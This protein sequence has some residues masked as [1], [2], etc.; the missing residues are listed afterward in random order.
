[1]I[2]WNKYQSKVTDQAQNRYLDYL[3]DPRF[4]RVNRLFLL[5][6]Q[7]RADSEVPTGYFLPKVETRYY[8]WL[9]LL[10]KNFLISQSKMNK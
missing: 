7:N 5:S 1:M 4:Q 10:N 9:W 2:I 6:F 8:V 3:I